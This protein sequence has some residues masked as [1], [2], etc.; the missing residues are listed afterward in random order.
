[1]FNAAPLVLYI[2]VDTYVPVTAKLE[3]ETAEIRK[4]IRGNSRLDDLYFD[5]LAARHSIEE[6]L[7]F[8]RHFK[9]NLETYRR[10]TGD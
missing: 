1:M 4:A 7:N 9:R 5:Q 3:I 2:Y 6:K 10:M 8:A